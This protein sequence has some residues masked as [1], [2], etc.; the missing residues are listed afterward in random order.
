M[1]KETYYGFRVNEEVT[2]NESETYDG[3]HHDKGTSFQITSFPPFI[4]STG[5]GYKYFV[6]GQDRF[7][8]ILRPSI[9]QIIK[10]KRK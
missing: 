10:Q 2:L 6:C 1:K 3:V 8:N 4:M 9:N 5:K 7:G